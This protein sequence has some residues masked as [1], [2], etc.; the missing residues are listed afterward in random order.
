MVRA[1]HYSLSY[2][3]SLQITGL[4]SGPYFFVPVYY[5]RTHMFFRII[6]DDLVMF[7]QVSLVV[8]AT[9]L[10]SALG[11]PQYIAK[12]DVEQKKLSGNVVASSYQ[13]LIIQFAVFF[14][15][16]HIISLHLIGITSADSPWVVLRS[17]FAPFTKLISYGIEYHVP[18]LVYTKSCQ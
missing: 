14:S 4:R 17:E 9:R 18:P 7:W 6:A 15:N 8:I 5:S 10:T 2:D 11:S 1:S 3:S 16:S 12:L 13:C